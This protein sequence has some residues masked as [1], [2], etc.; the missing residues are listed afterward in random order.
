MDHPLHLAQ[1]QLEAALP[2]TLSEDTSVHLSS[3]K[4]QVQDI[5]MQQLCEFSGVTATLG[6]KEARQ[7]ASKNKMARLLTYT[8]DGVKLY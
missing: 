8:L 4:I 7:T 6:P 3:P 1:L 2:P 5:W